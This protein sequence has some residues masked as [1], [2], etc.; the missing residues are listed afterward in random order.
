M[1]KTVTRIGAIMLVVG[2]A[3]IALAFAVSLFS[4]SRT[5]DV[6]NVATWIAV[7]GL[8]VFFIPIFAAFFT[9]VGTIGYLVIGAP[10]YDIYRLAVH[11]ESL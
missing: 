3:L 6:A 10:V 4:V 8:V 5:D 2:V 9:A 11:G 1:M 7:I